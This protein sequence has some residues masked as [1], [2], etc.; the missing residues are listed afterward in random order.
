[1]MWANKRILETQITR[2]R[3]V[4]EVKDNGGELVFTWRGVDPLGRLGKAEEFVVPAEYLDHLVVMLRES[5]C[6]DPASRV[7]LNEPEL[8]FV[9]VVKWED[10]RRVFEIRSREENAKPYFR[11]R[12][13]VREALRIAALARRCADWTHY[14]TQFVLFARTQEG[15]EWGRG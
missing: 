1:M 9:V 5:S 11:I 3:G 6:L 4:L 8:P 13:S 2:D 7:S 15:G 10:N 14:F 12:L